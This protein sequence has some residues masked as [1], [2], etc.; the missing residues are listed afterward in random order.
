MSEKKKPTA[1]EWHS[2]G[3]NVRKLKAI[4]GL[5]DAESDVALVEAIVQ[6]DKVRSDEDAEQVDDLLGAIMESPCFGESICPGDLVIQCFMGHQGNE[7]CMVVSIFEGNCE[8]RKNQLVIADDLPF[9][10]LAFI[11]KDEWIGWARV[12]NS[13]FG[14]MMEVLD[15]PSE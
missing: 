15:R 14:A 3:E 12:S 2:H 1:E 6:D 13:M 10:S 4:F 11:V 5:P 8:V 9:Q 7:L